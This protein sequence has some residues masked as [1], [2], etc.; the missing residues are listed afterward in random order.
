MAQHEVYVA[1]SIHGSN[2][3][4]TANKVIER[5]K[6]PTGSTKID[7]VTFTVGNSRTSSLRDATKLLTDELLDAN[8]RPLT[9]AQKVYDFFMRLA[10]LGWTVDAK[11]FEQKHKSKLAK[12]ASTEVPVEEAAPVK[13][14]EVEQ[15]TDALA[16]AGETQPAEQA[17]TPAAEPTEAAE[18]METAQ[19]ASDTQAEQTPTE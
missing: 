11:R 10:G 1:F 17:E 3:F 5:P 12:P 9:D 8:R 7:G 2:T 6:P 19:P 18:Q 4:I 16:H 14:E 15:M 13:D